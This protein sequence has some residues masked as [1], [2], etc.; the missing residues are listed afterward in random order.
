ML[1]AGDTFYPFKKIPLIP[2]IGLGVKN[3]QE[4]W[5]PFTRAMLLYDFHIKDFSIG[6]MIMYD[7]FPNFKDIMSYGVTFGYSLHD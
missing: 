6:P 2:G 4:T 5:D 1:S 7:F 3:K